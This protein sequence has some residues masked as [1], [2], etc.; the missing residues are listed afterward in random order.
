MSFYANNKLDRNFFL[1]SIIVL[2]PLLYGIFFMSKY[3]YVLIFFITVLTAIMPSKN[4][5]LR[6]FFFAYYGVS[7]FVITSGFCILYFI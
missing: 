5:K 6:S 3:L 1:Y 4:K 2:T 7:L